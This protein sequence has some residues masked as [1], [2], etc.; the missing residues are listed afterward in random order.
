MPPFVDI[1]NSMFTPILY[2]GI[3]VSTVLLALYYHVARRSSIRHLQGPP[4]QSWTLGMLPMILME[5]LVNFFTG[6]MRELE[7]SPVG[8]CDFLWAERYG[9]TYRMKGGYGVRFS[10]PCTFLQPGLTG[11]SSVFIRKT[12]YSPRTP[13][14]FNTSFKR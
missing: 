12:Y 5:L 6:N 1:A 4:A 2:V 11:H 7:V 9:Q 10:M 14:R 3:A 13:K 8:D